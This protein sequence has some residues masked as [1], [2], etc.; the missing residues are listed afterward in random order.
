MR[1]IWWLAGALLVGVIIYI[2][3]DIFRPGSTFSR[4]ADFAVEDTSAVSRVVLTRMVQG[5]ARY[6][7]DL[8][9]TAGNAWQLNG[10]YPAFSPRV[11][12][13]LGVMHLLQVR[14][15]LAGQGQRTAQEI[16]KTQHIRM[17]AF[18][19]ETPLKTY[20]I[21]TQT[22]DG[23]GTV[24]KMLNA[25]EAFVVEVPGFQGYVNAYFPM[26]KALWR[27][28]KLADI[29]ATRLQRINVSYRDSLK[30]HLE[31]IRNAQGLQ[32]TFEDGDSTKQA[33][34]L[35]QF[36]GTMYAETFATEEYP[37]LLEK[38][39][40]SPADVIIY[41]QYTDQREQE[42]HLYERAENPNNF[43][44]WTTGSEELLTVQHFVIDPYLQEPKDLQ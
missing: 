2:S 3:L 18:D 23:K 14:E 28:N 24:M 12:Q 19:G 22:S 17:D 20:L 37:G 8:R 10:E 44:C 1:L 32:A 29:E 35:A 38:L 16:L 30:E 43:F 34:Y 36:Q 13:M 26:S 7:I 42:I 39:K 40:E 11:T 33:D 27:E 31:F 9:R 5:E 4:E 15:R 21:G 6:Q 25:D 41:L